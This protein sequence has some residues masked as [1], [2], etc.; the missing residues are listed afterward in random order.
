MFD[1][2]SVLTFSRY[3]NTA[4]AVGN[5]VWSFGKGLPLKI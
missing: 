4:G 1:R 5:T 2:K 3:A